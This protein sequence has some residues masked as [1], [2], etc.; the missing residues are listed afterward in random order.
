RVPPP[1]TQPRQSA[2]NTARTSPFASTSSLRRA[3]PPGPNTNATKWHRSDD[4]CL[5]DE[6]DALREVPT[7][8]EWTV[9]TDPAV[10]LNEIRRPRRRGERDATR[11]E[12]TSAVVVR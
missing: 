2:R 8:C 3:P 7:Q 12:A 11:E 1:A 9:A 5:P 10:D 4:L 6:I